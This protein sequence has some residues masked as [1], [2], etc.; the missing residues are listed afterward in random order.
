M[1]SKNTQFPCGRPAP[2]SHEAEPDSH[3]QQVV[4]KRLETYQAEKEMR[5]SEARNRI[6]DVILTETQHF[7]GSDL[8]KKVQ[9]AH[10][11][12]GAATVYRTLPLL[13]EAGILRESLNDPSGQTIYELDRSE[14]HDHIVCLDCSAIIEFHE[15]KLESIQD[16]AVSKLAFK[17]I[18]HKHVVYAHCEYRSKKSR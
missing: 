11:T 1:S 10:P 13:V 14:H 8:V 2:R 15:E 9:A 4:W 17:P 6:I 7:T 3:E 12:I 18:Q 5:H 16:Q